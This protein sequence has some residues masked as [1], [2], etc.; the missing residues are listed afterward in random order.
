MQSKQ[1]DSKKIW[2]NLENKIIFKNFNDLENLIN[3]LLNNEQ[4]P[5][6]ILSNISKN[7]K[8]SR[9]MI[10]RQLDKILTTF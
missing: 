10:E 7:F 4:S 8:H 2:G 9:N 5:N 1:I 3:K 6:D